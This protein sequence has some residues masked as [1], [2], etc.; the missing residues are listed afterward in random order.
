MIKAG[1]AARLAA[2]KLTL[3]LS[4]ARHAFPRTRPNHRQILEEKL[5]VK[6]KPAAEKKKPTAGKKKPT[7]EKKPAA[8]KRKAEAKPPAPSALDEVT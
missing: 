2:S 3:S 7:E 5:G 6:K 8:G 4:P 1:C